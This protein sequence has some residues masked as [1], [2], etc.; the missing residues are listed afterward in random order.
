MMAS[1][2]S[3]SKGCGIYHT[4]DIWN[5]LSPKLNKPDVNHIIKTDTSKIIP[6]DDIEENSTDIVLLAGN[7]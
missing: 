3:M 5:L 4:L 6:T 2:F 7:L 1:L